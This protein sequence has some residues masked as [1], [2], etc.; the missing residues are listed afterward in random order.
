MRWLKS[1]ICVISVAVLLLCAF[2]PAADAALFAF[3][4]QFDYSKANTAWL[5]DLVAKENMT[6]IEQIAA[7]LTLEAVPD[8]P[9]TETPESFKNEVAYFCT[10][11]TIDEQS[12]RAAYIYVFQMMGDY[13]YIIEAGTTDEQIKEYLVDK[14]IVYP[15]NAD[16]DTL[17]LA[18][19][20]YVAISSG[21]LDQYIDGSSLS[22]IQ[23]EKAIIDYASAICGIDTASLSKWIDGG[24]ILSLDDF[25]LAT[26][27]LSLWTSGYSVTPQTPAAEVYRQ[28]AVMVIEQQGITAGADLS[29]EE[30][31]LRYMAAMLGKSY[32]I[33][34]DSTK[35]SEAIAAHNVPFYILQL[36]GQ[37]AGLSIKPTVYSYEDAFYLVAD[38][39]DVFDIEPGEFYAD[40]FEYNVHLAKRRSSIWLYPTTYSGVSDAKSVSVTVD[41]V[42]VKDNFYSE[43]SLDPSLNMQTL[44][45]KVTYTTRSVKNDCTYLLNVYQGTGA[46]PEETTK[47]ENTSSPDNSTGSGTASS[48]VSSILSSFGVST[49]LDDTLSSA[50]LSLPSKITS[51]ISVLAPS[52]DTAEP[53]TSFIDSGS[54]VFGSLFNILDTVGERVNFDLSGIGGLSLLSFFNDNKS[55]ES[56]V[57]FLE[58][59]FD[60]SVTTAPPK[61][62]SGELPGF[63]PGNAAAITGNTVESTTRQESISPAEVVGSPVQ[64][65][66]SS[67]YA[68]SDVNTSQKKNPDSAKNALLFLS[69]VAGIAAVAAVV[70]IVTKSRKH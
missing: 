51:I 45:I 65:G 55:K 40:I 38:N 37:K 26:A 47:D 31:K 48:I 36:L 5:T 21:A 11:Y 27:R 12:L 3:E 39:S 16:E 33:Q 46:Q 67:T 49:D 7:R 56:D 4:T 6:D 13:S 52:F 61:I 1:F 10:I 66:E 68:V 15:E 62:E 29:T 32:D 34:V 2:S 28:L 9:Y 17:I 8:Y 64:Q 23:L 70:L 22:G 14:G 42:P 53:T 50:V 20:L 60:R 44:S 19:A 41:G 57:K 35:L 24:K 63:I 43:V 54:N 69:V 59:S 58:V 18:R 25:V 30:L